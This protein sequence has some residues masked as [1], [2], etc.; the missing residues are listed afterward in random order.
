MSSTSHSVATKIGGVDPLAPRARLKTVVDVVS[1]MRL[2]GGSRKR[3]VGA[4]RPFSLPWPN[5]RAWNAPGLSTINCLKFRG[6]HAVRSLPCAG[7]G[8]RERRL[9]HDRGVL[10]WTFIF[11]K[12][13]CGDVSGESCEIR[14]PRNSGNYEADER[15]E[16]S[17]QATGRTFWRRISKNQRMV[18]Q[19]V[20]WEV[21]TH[22]RAQRKTDGDA[23]Q[24]I[25][26]C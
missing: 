20:N 22:T 10:V 15:C 18:L 21:G 11:I 9:L 2:A 25:P 1:Q 12:W 7:Q 24:P 8:R 26:D 5:P 13:K 23:S 16:I 19:A 17:G 6:L 14:F 3:T 4:V